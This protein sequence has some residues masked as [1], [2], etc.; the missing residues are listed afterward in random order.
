[1]KIRKR[2]GEN[3][4]L[5]YVLKTT[6]YQTYNARD[7]YYAD[8]AQQEG[9]LDSADRPAYLLPNRGDGPWW[10]TD[11]K[12][13]QHFN[14]LAEAKSERDKVVAL[15]QQNNDKPPQHMEIGTRFYT[16]LKK[17]KTNRMSKVI[18]GTE[19]IVASRDRAQELLDFIEREPVMGMLIDKVRQVLIDIPLDFPPEAHVVLDIATV[20]DPD[21]SDP[22][23]P[24]ATPKPEES[25][26]RAATV[27]Q[28]QGYDDDSGKIAWIFAKNRAI[29]PFGEETFI[30]GEKLDIQPIIKALKLSGHDVAE[31]V[32]IYG[33][34]PAE[35]KRANPK[36]GTRFARDDEHSI[37][38]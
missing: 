16:K 23:D 32:R 30:I 6:R 4:V 18:P 21:P 38:E 26:T 22:S 19:H 5:R 10:T 34:K 15:Y 1:M 29:D 25:L 2:K 24:S 7:R 9:V 28:W 12:E 27:L 20:P 3:T 13:A 14:T 8:R 37:S 17:E 33:R 11:A 31:A 36:P 35:I